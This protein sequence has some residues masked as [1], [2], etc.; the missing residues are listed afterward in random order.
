MVANEN[1]CRPP[2]DED[3]VRSVARSVA[4]YAPAEAPGGGRRFHLTGYGNAERLVARHG[5]DIRYCHA[6]GKWVIWNGRRWRVDDRGAI[7]RLAKAT[8]RAIYAE[9]AAEADDDR[10][11]ATAKWAAQSESGGKIEEM[12]R[13]AQSEP[14]IPIQPDD[15]DADPL[16]LNVRNGTLDL[17]T[18]ELHPHRREDLITKLAPVEYDPDADCP[19]WRRFLDRIMGG[20][21]EVIEFLRRAIG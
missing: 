6:W 12:I 13:L 4:R 5:S 3:E 17:R 19:T 20:N 10:R 21:R 2:L 8:S 14:G 11:K 7:V 1:R 16:L 9:A 15:L 18:G